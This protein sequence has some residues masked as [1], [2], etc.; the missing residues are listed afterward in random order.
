[1]ENY[2]AG[3]GET[4]ERM[5]LIKA[6]GVAGDNEL[7]YEFNQRL[8]PFIFP[9]IVSADLLDEIAAV[10]ARIERDVVGP[11][12]LHRNVKLG[13]GGI[14]EIEFILQTLQL[15]HGARNAFLQER[16]SLKTLVTLEHLNILPPNEVRLLRDAYIFLRTVEHRLQIQ[17]EQQTHTLPARRE[18][19]IGIART[20][21]YEQVDTFAEVL[22]SHTSAV[23]SVFDRLLKS[24]EART[25]ESSR[26]LS[27]FRDP[28]RAVRALTAL[29]EGPSAVHVAPRTRRLFAKLEPELL[30]W[31]AR[32]AEPDAALNRL[33]RFVDAY[34]TRGLLF[35]T[36]LASPKLLE[37]LVR[38]FDASAIFSDVVIRRPQLIEEI[39]RGKTLGL[40]ISK[41][42][43][44]EDLRRNEEKLE[45][46]AWVRVYRS[47]AVVRILLRDIL[48]MASPEE[49]QLEMTN[50]AEACL[51]YC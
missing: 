37:L 33:V 27:A 12:E 49:L 20:L 38:L 29:R 31:S 26:D 18:A 41:E 46:L 42:Q 47:G 1:M 43:F 9:R 24:S 19:W 5:A 30:A 7:L 23:R 8:Q 32:V 6:R 48:G 21:G 16:N 25:K 15:L 36:M 44:L 35:E 22:R 11:A 14:R 51:T 4:W 17:N 10:K 34:G 39:T 28:E 40:S 2:Y 45:P 50:L 3:Y 13:F